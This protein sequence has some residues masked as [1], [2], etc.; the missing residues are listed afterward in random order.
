M[1]VRRWPISKP[2]QRTRLVASQP[3][4]PPLAG[5]VLRFCVFSR[6]GGDFLA[7]TK[8]IYNSDCFASFGFLSFHFL[9]SSLCV[10]G[11]LCV[12]ALFLHTFCLSALQ[13]SAASGRAS[14]GTS[15]LLV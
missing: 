5:E 11:L 13:Q 2:C 1:Q 8:Y 7:E 12:S 14:Q 6:G 4:R 9:Q 10:S 15:K 3:L